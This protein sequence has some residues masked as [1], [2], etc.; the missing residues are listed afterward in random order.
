LFLLNGCTTCH[1]SYNIHCFRSAVLLSTCPGGKALIVIYQPA[2]TTT[3]CFSTATIITERDSILR[4]LLGLFKMA[5]TLSSHGPKW[6]QKFLKQSSSPVTRIVLLGEP[7][8]V[9]DPS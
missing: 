8:S 4:K 2:D 3:Y 5:Q 7:L 6:K 9:V 1:P